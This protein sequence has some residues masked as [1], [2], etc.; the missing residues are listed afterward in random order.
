MFGSVF[1]SS[2]RNWSFAAMGESN[3][4][5]LGKIRATIDKGCEELE[6]LLS[7]YRTLQTQSLTFGDSVSVHFN[8]VDEFLSLTVNDFLAS[9]L[10]QL[11]QKAALE[12]SDRCLCQLILQEKRYR[13]EHYLTRHPEGRESE[14][15]DEYILYRKG[16]LSKFVIDPLLLKT[17]RSSVD[18]RYRTIIGGIPAAIAMSFFLVLYVMQGSWFIINSQPFVLF[19]VLLY[20]LKDRLKEELRFISFRQVAKWFSD[21]STQILDP[22]NE[23]VIG[24]VKEY[25]NFIGE[26]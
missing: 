10:E 9:V 3:G 7:Q 12:S 2:V 6:R 1:H 24:T 13:E 20:V 19:T 15:L 22:L 21:Y 8:Y 4:S 5:N 18:Q 14:E 17:S 23:A 25:V 11:R 16:L 26:R